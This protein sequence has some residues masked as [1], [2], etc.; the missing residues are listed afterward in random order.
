MERSVELLGPRKHAFARQSAVEVDRRA[1][2]LAR[3]VGRD[4]H[5]NS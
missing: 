1:A 5:C 3:D 4:E 2:A